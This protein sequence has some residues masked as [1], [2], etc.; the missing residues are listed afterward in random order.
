MIN[1]SSLSF[2]EKKP[3]CPE[4][5]SFFGTSP[6]AKKGGHGRKSRCTGCRIIIFYGTAKRLRNLGIHAFGRNVLSQ[7]GVRIQDIMSNV[8]RTCQS[9]IISTL[10]P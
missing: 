2:G 9:D 4:E 6:L 1:Y 5:L 3:L 8:F 10:S 7:G